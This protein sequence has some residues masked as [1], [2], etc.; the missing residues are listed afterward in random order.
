MI[1]Y[2]AV[3]DS[4]H[5]FFVQQALKNNIDFNNIKAKV[6]SFTKNSAKIVAGYLKMFVEGSN[7]HPV[8]NF[9]VIDNDVPKNVQV[10]FLQEVHL[11]SYL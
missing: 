8:K 10:F 9:E 6:T 7:K 3:I 11:S 4:L 1:L 5:M 2:A